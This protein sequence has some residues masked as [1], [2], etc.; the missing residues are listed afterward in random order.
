MKIGN[1]H[2]G[3]ISSIDYDK[4]KGFIISCSEDNSIKFFNRKDGKC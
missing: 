2:K 3:Y 4:S 1:A